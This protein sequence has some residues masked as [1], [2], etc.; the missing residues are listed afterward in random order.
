[1]RGNS[2][3]A[4]FPSSVGSSAI[5][6]CGLSNAAFKFRGILIIS[7]TLNCIYERILSTNDVKSTHGQG[8][9]EQNQKSR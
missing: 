9:R 3:S 4:A 5:V 1:M 6:A 7:T 2:T 8:S